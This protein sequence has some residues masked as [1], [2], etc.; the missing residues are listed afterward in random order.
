MKINSGDT[1]PI[2]ETR[3]RKTSDG[4]TAAKIARAGDTLAKVRHQKS[5]LEF[6]VKVRS[7]Q[8][9][10]IRLQTTLSGLEKIHE[11]FQRDGGVEEDFLN[12]AIENTLFEKEQVL[13][14]HK[15]E[16]EAA[17][18]KGDPEILNR[19]ISDLRSEIRESITRFQTANQN[20]E[21]VT[22]RGEDFNRLL[23][24]V[25][26]DIRGMKD[27]GIRLTRDRVMDLLG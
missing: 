4:R 10:L 13:L 15:N 23:D 17:D 25:V 27:S 18:L 2:G 5:D 26:K 22:Q 24:T 19:L 3:L 12:S 7:I 20:Q 14:P 16:I 21:S 11:H 8:R 9:S 6:Q 1:A